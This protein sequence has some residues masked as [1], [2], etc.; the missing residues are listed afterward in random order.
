MINTCLSVTL[1]LAVFLWSCDPSRRIEMKNRSADTAEVVWK[2][3]T[4]S[5]GFNPFNLN[6][7]KEL[8]FV[9]PPH[10]NE[11]V[12][13][14]FGMGT[15]TKSEVENVI[16]RMASLQIKSQT[17]NIKIDSLPALRDFLLAHRKGSSKIEIVIDR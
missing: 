6:N 2:A 17:Q 3:K 10:K 9:L 13:L 12:K 1:L 14:T 5:I 15:W 16:H 8:R 4:D 7:S 11:A